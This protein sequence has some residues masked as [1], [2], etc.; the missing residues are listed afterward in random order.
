MDAEQE[1][2]EWEI[3]WVEQGPSFFSQK[4]LHNYF[5]CHKVLETLTLD[6]NT[7]VNILNRLDL[8]LIFFSLS[9]SLP[10]LFH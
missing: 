1:L 6:T 8:V 2:W 9:L 10:F 7:E 4:N 5:H 3:G